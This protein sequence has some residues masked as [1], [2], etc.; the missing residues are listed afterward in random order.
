M[1]VLHVITDLYTGGAERVLFNLL[2]AGLAHRFENRV[3][4]LRE[5]TLF[6]QQ[7][8][9][10][11]VPVV[12]LGMGNN[13]DI[14][15]AFRKLKSET[16]N[17]GPDV[18][19]GWMYHGNMAAYLA[20]RQPSV[21]P[22]LSWNIRQTLYSLKSEKLM[23]Q[24]VIHANRFFSSRAAAIIYNSRLSLSQHE[25]F[26]LHTSSS[27]FIPNGFDTNIYSPS[28]SSRAR[29][30]SELEINDNCLIVGTMARL[31][32]IKNH[33]GFFRAAVKLAKVLP[34]VHFL[35][36]GKG[37]D[38][39]NSLYLMIVPDELRAR[40]HLLGERH[41]VSALMQAMDVFCSCSFAEAFPNVLGE[42]MACQLPSVV[43]DVGD[44]AEIVGESG[45]VVPPDND[46]ELL[47][48]M[49][50]V[51]SMTTEERRRLGAIARER[52]KSKYSLDTAVSTYSDL[53]TALAENRAG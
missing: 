34:N 30:R 4:S 53:Y 11:D 51:L 32:P 15:P 38:I 25:K 33:E 13:Y 39:T 21:R 1:K 52:V 50:R 18:I 6:S 35:L 36:A 29:I 8:R 49:L 7:I 47:S 9:E 37:V 26:G 19:Q 48:A 43:T 31:H 27:R 5:E 24:F 17:F 10:L 40:F 20:A 44:C 42:A 23:T 16:I 41:D 2:S 45:V 3:I 28:E 12:S 22:A 14:F 46:E